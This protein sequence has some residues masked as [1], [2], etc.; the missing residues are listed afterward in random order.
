MIAELEAALPG[1]EGSTSYLNDGSLRVSPDGIE[2]IAD[3]GSGTILSVKLP[4][5]GV[6][7]GV[8]VSG[9]VFLNS[10][11]AVVYSEFHCPVVM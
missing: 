3:W 2:C 11:G 9:V 1:L 7:R 10:I 5:R 6:R 8:S 4:Q